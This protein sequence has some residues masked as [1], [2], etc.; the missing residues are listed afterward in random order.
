[1]LLGC[2]LPLAALAN[3][4]EGERTE[5]VVLG[6]AH[7]AMLVAETYQ[8]AVFRAWFERVQPDA[9]C[10]ERPPEEFARNTHYDFTYE[11]QH[12]AVPYAPRRPHRRDR[13]RRRRGTLPC[14]PRQRGGGRRLHLDRRAGPRAARYLR[15]SLRQPDDSRARAARGSARAA[16]AGRRA[17]GRRAQGPV[18]RIAAADEGGP[19]SRVLGRVGRRSALTRA[20]R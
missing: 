20:R 4:D 19:A 17:D 15:R 9:I 11:I 5:V 1:L 8:P 6:V 16:Q 10:I 2:L 13:Q 7:S 14:H 12:I 3:P 18:A